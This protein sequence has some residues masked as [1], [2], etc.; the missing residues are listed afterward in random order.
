MTSVNALVASGN[1]GTATRLSTSLSQ[2]FRSVALAS[3]G[4]EAR[5]AIPRRRIQ[6]VV[7]DLETIGIS[8]VQ[9]LC[10]DFS[11]ASIVCTHRLADEVM[12][13]R[14]LEAGAIDCCHDGDIQ[15][16]LQA[17]SRNL[18]LARSSAA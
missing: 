7:V 8:D 12:W 1:S 9:R 18:V 16:I 14:A 17:A 2:H 13:V 10:E 4:Q 3:S 11:A 15:G 6:F 5:D